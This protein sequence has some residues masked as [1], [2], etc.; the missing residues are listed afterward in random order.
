MS[1]LSYQEALHDMA[2]RLSIG[3]TY[4]KLIIN[5]YGLAEDFVFLDA[6][7]AFEKI[8][9]LNSKPVI[10]KRATEVFHRI[11]KSGF[12]WVLFGQKATENGKEQEVTR[13]ID[14]LNRWI[15]VTTYSREDMHFVAFYQDTTPKFETSDELEHLQNLQAMFDEHTAVMLLTEPL[16]GKIMDANLAACDFYGYTR[17]ELKSMCIDDISPSFK[18]EMH[19]RHMKPNLAQDHRY[20]FFS[21]RLKNGEIRTVDIYSSPGSGARERNLIRKL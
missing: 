18:Q 20:L 3:Y 13:Y 19:R 21:H 16:T 1:E 14:T 11:K 7:P 12:N 10:G 6:N 17:T 15:S 9:G 5:D 8:F 4:Q 2:Q